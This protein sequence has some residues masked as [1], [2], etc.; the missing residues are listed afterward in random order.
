MK[1]NQEIN[2][3]MHNVWFTSDLHLYHDNILWINKRPFKN[4]D[5]MWEYFKKEWNDKVK[6][7]DYVFVLGDVLWGSQASKLANMANLLNGH[8][9]IVLGNHDKEKTGVNGKK[10]N[11]D[12]FDS[13]ER[14]DFIKVK[15]K[16]YGIDQLIYLSHYP[17]MSWPQK[18]RGSIMLHGHV[19]GTMDCINE[20][21]KDL[22]VDV[23]VDGKLA[24]MHILSF[25]DIY[26]Y[27]LHKAGDMPLAQY[28][29]NMYKTSSENTSVEDTEN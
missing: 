28:M 4:C 11:F 19:H 13:C 18:N 14:S 9:C 2:L 26:E 16:K 8:I 25:N 6:P 15:S 17:A 24:N 7:E 5:E 29:Q 21:S 3:D 22:R 27:M 23:G 10:G 12:V 1:W 20:Q